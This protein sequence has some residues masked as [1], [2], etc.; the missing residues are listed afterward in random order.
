MKTLFFTATFALYAAAAYAAQDTCVQY[1]KYGAIK[2][3]KSEVGEVQGSNGMEHSAEFRAYNPRTGVY[4]YL[5][6]ISDNNE[7]GDTWDVNYEVEVKRSIRGCRV[8]S[9]KREI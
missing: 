1:A 7:D 4:T 2:V 5:V 6:T 3:Y 8:V 9:V